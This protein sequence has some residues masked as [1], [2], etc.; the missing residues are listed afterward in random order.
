MTRTFCALVLAA[1]FVSNASIGGKQAPD[2]KT[3]IQLDLP[4]SLH[5]KNTGGSDGAGLC[6]FTSIAHSARWQHVELLEN[7]H[8]WMKQYAGGGY[9]EK[10]NQKIAQIAKEKGR[11]PPRYLQV[12][13]GRE[14]LDLL[15]AAVASGRMPAVTYYFSPSGRYRGQRILHMVSLVHL[16]SQYACILDNNYPGVDQYE[17][18]TVDEFL[19]AFTGGRSGWAVV[20]L[21]A[22][23]PPLPW[24]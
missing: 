18:L 10:V 17:W 21:D 24:N 16:D 3:E 9:P 13:G 22:G 8:D 14:L 23:P 12:E 6:V 7:F 19:R 20:L 4:G 15:R 2:G 11:P 1:L 5:L